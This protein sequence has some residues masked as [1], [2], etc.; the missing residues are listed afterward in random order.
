[1]IWSSS[2]E[3]SLLCFDGWID[4]YGFDYELLNEEFDESGMK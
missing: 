2:L 1:M 4:A 3:S